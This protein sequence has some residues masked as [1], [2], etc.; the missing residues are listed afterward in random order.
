MPV[1][2][3]LPINRF[4]HYRVLY[5]KLVYGSGTFGT[6]VDVAGGMITEIAG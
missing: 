3:V 6:R 2:I 4:S 5:V 1:L